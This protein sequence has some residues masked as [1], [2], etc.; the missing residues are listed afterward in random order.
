MSHVLD[1]PIWSALNTSHSAL[2]QG[3]GLARRYPAD[4]SVFAADADDS[5]DSV[6]AFAAL[7]DAERGLLRLQVGEPPLP[8]GFAQTL[9]ADGVQ[10]LAAR[11]FPEIADDR[12]RPLT[13]EDA[14]AMLELATLTRPGPFSLK[15]LSLGRFWGIKVDGRLIAMAGQRLKQ[16]GYTELSGVCTHPDFAGRGLGRLL[17]LYVA[18]QIQEEGDQ[19]FLHAYATNARAIALYESIGFE[20]RTMMHV[21]LV[22]RAA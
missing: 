1:R 12:I 6:A 2:A 19:P 9:K 22:Q 7:P 21:S 20:I 5:P 10:M 17:S 8:P 13:A 11:D 14:G 15:V 18:R 3:Q 16:P 4:V